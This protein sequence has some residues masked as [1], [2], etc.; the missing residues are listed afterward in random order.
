MCFGTE[1]LIPSNFVGLWKE[2]GYVNEIGEKAAMTV[3][4]PAV[5]SHYWSNVLIVPV[6]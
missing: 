2:I 1:L 3:M 6:L 5:D 4:N